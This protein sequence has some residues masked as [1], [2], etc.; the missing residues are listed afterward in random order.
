MGGKTPTP[1]AV[2]GC[3]QLAPAR[4]ARRHRWDGD[5]RASEADSQRGR[6]DGKQRRD[7]EH[8]RPAQSIPRARGCW[9]VDACAT[10][11]EQLAARW[12]HARADDTEDQI[13]GL[14]VVQRDFVL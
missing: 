10:R 2:P 5:R 8:H 12:F 14:D 6:E 9:Q 3:A 11:V 1:P 7:A 13:C 4:D